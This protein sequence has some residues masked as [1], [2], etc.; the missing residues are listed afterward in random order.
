M[1]WKNNQ[2][3]GL[4]AFTANSFHVSVCLKT[5]LT[6]CWGEIKKIMGIMSATYSQKIQEKGKYDKMLT[7]GESG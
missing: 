3:L 7:I 5:F 4:E 2:A 6:K 1:S